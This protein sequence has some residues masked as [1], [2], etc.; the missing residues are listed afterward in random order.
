MISTY[1]VALWYILLSAV[2]CKK[3]VAANV[4]AVV[5]DNFSHIAQAMAEPSSTVVC[6]Q[7]SSNTTRD[8]GVTDCKMYCASFIW[9]K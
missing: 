4:N 9:Y 3:C 7:S 8:L 6:L 2:R 5:S 1:V